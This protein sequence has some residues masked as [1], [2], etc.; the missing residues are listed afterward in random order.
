MTR[1][2]KY[3]DDK[4]KILYLIVL[5][6][7]MLSAPVFA[8]Q[9]TLVEIVPADAWTGTGNNASVVEAGDAIVTQ[10]QNA[11]KINSNFD[12]IYG[13]SWYTQSQIDTMLSGKQDTLVS[14]AN[15]KTINSTSL[16]GSGDIT[17]AGGTVDATVIDGSANPVAGNAV[18]D[19]LALKANTASLGAA[20]SLGATNGTIGHVASWVDDGDG[21]AALPIDVSGSAITDTGNYFT[22]DTINAAFQQIGAG[23][24]GGASAIADLSDWPSGISATELS[25]L[26]N[27][28]ENLRL[29]MTGIE[30]DIAAV[31][32]G[33]PLIT[34][35]TYSDETC[36][37][38]Q[39]AISTSPSMYWCIA[40][41]T[42][43]YQVVSGANLVWAGW[44]NPTPTTYSLTITP[45]DFT[46]ADLFTYDSTDYTTQ[47]VITGLTADATFTVT[48][49]SGNSITCTGTGITDNTGGSYTANT[50]TQSVVAACVSSAAGCS[51][52]VD[53]YIGYTGATAGQQGV[54]TAGVIYYER[55]TPGE[56]GTV[57]NAHVWKYGN[58]GNVR[59]G[60]FDNTGTLLAA[61]ALTSGGGDASLAAVHAALVEVST[62]S[63]CLDSSTTY[64]IGAWFDTGW[65]GPGT[66]AWMSGPTNYSQA[67]ASFGD[68][69][70]ADTNA[71]NNGHLVLTLNNS[72]GTF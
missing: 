25:Y 39:Y 57:G 51:G 72:A 60:L 31:E 10:M 59:I 13:W 36:T 46:G 11:G 49:D 12:E 15:I 9:E 54:A 34:A 8:A 5:M 68:F 47:Q 4:M 27:L 41:N 2:W 22:T 40:T 30:E 38:G 44:D 16:L 3:K 70:P 26:D 61:T 63:S 66:S 43:D 69:T 50:D 58:S 37:V 45:S 7:L 65:E 28:N 67:L 14:G 1:Q 55:F 48:P 42:W 17:I 52:G 6:V 71:L 21:N 20:A 24:F 35:P 33:S 19:G 64:I 62:G 56:D 32:V 53:G 23:G 18:Y 29:W